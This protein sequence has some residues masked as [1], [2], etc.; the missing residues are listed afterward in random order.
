MIIAAVAFVAAP[1]LRSEAAAQMPDA[2]AALPSHRQKLE[3]QKLE[4]YTAIKE[5]EF[6]YRMGK[7]SDTD[8]AIM[9]DKYAAQALTAI[10]ALAAARGGDGGRPSGRRPA[11]IAFCPTCGH[12][13]PPRANFCPACGLS[14]KEAVA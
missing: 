8:L 5:V 9:R 1:F 13:I 11:R 3:R 4:A 7:L 10:E 6:D 2:A 14:L 12:T